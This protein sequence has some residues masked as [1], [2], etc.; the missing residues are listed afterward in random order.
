MLDDYGMKAIVD[1][2]SGALSYAGL[3]AVPFV[4]GKFSARTVTSA[5]FAYTGFFYTVMTGMG[6]KLKK[7]GLRKYKW[8]LGVLIGLAGM[9]NNAISASKKVLVGDATDYME[10]YSEKKYGQPIRSD[11]LL[12]ATQNIVGKVNSLIKVNLYNGLFSAIGYKNK[13]TKSNEKAVQTP[14]TLHGIY[15]IA[16]LCGFIGNLLPAISFMLDNYSGKRK[17][18]I[19][20]ELCEMREKRAAVLE[21]E[22]LSE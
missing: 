11:G 12:S 3:A 2:I 17:D 14:Q 22:L 6:L 19:Y 20:A 5:G 16:S 15:A 7:E 1:M 18:R 9:P 13:D 4:T 21:N 8:I 10:W